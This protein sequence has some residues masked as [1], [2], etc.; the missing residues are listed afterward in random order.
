MHH[1]FVRL[2]GH[3]KDVLSIPCFTSLKL[4]TQRG[5]REVSVRLWEGDRLMQRTF[6]VLRV[7]LS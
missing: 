4:T 6:G 3:L 2:L 7:E 5:T 1:C